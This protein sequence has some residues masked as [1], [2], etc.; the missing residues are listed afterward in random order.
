MKRRDDKWARANFWG[1]GYVRNLNCGD[2]FMEIYI[3]IQTDTHTQ[4]Y[5]HVDTNMYQNIKLYILNMC[6]LLHVNS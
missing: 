5:I 4:M 2:G 1:C 3:Y 6:G